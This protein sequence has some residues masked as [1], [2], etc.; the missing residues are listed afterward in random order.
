MNH[1]LMAL[2]AIQPEQANRFLGVSWLNLY[3]KQ[4]PR[5][6]TE[7]VLPRLDQKGFWCGVSD[8]VRQDESIVRAELSLTRLPDGGIIGTARDVTEK[9]NA[10][11]EHKTM[12][13]QL[14]QAQKME[15]IG[16]LAGGIAH[17][18]NNILAAIN[19]YAEFLIEDLPDESAEQKFAGNILKAGRQARDLVDQILT[20]SRRETSGRQIIDLRNPVREALSMLEATLPK[21]IELHK[22]IEMAKVPLYANVTEI[23]QIVMNLAVNAKD[24]MKEDR[25]SLKIGLKRVGKLEVFEGLPRLQIQSDAAL[26]IHIEDV[27]VNH[28]RLSLGGI[29]PDTDYA[30]LS[31]EDSGTGMSRAVMEHVL[32]PFFTTKPVDQGTGLGLSIVH[33]VVSAYQG[34][35]IIDSILGTGTRFDIYF[36]L[37]CETHAEP[38]EYQESKKTQHAGHILLVDD[39]EDVRTM[40]ET[41]LKRLGYTV[42]TAQNGLEALQLV[43]SR[44]SDF[45]VILTDQNMPKMSGLELVNQV[46]PDFPHIPFVFLSGYSLESIEAL[47][48]DHPAIYEILRKPILQK[49]LDE[50][51][52][53]V[54]SKLKNVEEYA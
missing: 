32:E 27:A 33:G 47:I 52:G 36:P 2:H 39:Q 13:D 21:T 35:L 31:V 3:N 34:V 25:G 50:S 46:Y 29:V 1:A 42:E 10:E 6:I 5:H 17:D 54:F 53:I 24:A 8:V 9:E 37:E 20:F 11:R 26:P 38:V 44:A 40:T 43:R 7:E 41:M 45:D 28:T 16:R 15:A 23:V 12:Q 30:C 14:F 49:N 18:F 19:G 51:L 48:Q 4:G 22:N